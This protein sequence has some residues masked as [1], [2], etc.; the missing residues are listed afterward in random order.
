MGYNANFKSAIT[1]NEVVASGISLEVV[2]PE[3]QLPTTATSNWNIGLKLINPV[4]PI[5]I[6]MTDYNYLSQYS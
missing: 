4:T 2:I 6:D 3:L 1:V 5:S